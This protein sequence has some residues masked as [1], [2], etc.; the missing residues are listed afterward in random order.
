MMVEQNFQPQTRDTTNGPNLHTYIP[1]SGTAAIE[2]NGVTYWPEG[3]GPA[4]TGNA[5]AAAATIPVMIQPGQ[6]ATVPMV[7]S[8]PFHPFPSLLQFPYLPYVPAEYYRQAFYPQASVSVQDFL[9]HLTTS[10][11]RIH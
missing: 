6:P 5:T 3:Q 7:L 4:S 2:V 8:A 1:R 9:S 10:T 11:L